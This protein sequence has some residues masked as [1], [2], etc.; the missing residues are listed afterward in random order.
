MYFRLSFPILGLIIVGMTIFL[1]SATH[2]TEPP[3]PAPVELIK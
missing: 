3:S 1:M 2:R